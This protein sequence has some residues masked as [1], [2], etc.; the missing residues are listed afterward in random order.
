MVSS[1]R[2][3]T[4][5]AIRLGSTEL[6]LQRAYPQ[7]LKTAGT[8]GKKTTRQYRVKHAMFTVRHGRVCAIKLS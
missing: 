7:L 6:D 2:F 8:F 4:A 1:K 3:R 5:L